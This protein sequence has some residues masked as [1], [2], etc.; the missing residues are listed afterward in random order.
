DLHQ[1]QNLE[2]REHEH[3]SLVQI[4]ACSAL[5]KGQRMFDSLFVYEN[6]PVE[7]KLFSSAEELQARSDTARTHTNYPLTV[8]VYPGDDLGL[9]LSYD[10]RYFDEET[11]DRLLTD[12]KR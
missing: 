1:R 7:S 11:V 9:H 10:E 8:V 5:E 12:F 2:L 4:Q 6:A 3:L